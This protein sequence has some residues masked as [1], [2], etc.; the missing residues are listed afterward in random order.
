MKKTPFR[1]AASG[2][3]RRVFPLAL[4]AFVALACGGPAKGPE[5][6][7]TPGEWR[8]FE[9]TL[10]ATGNR[11]ALRLGPDRFATIFSLSG[12]LLLVGERRLGQGFQCKMIGFN[13]NTKGIGGWS[14]W[15][16]T[17]GDQVFSEIKGEPI[18]AGRR[19][20]GT[21]QGGTGRYAGITG[22]YE[23]V[24]KL[25]VGDESTDEATFQGRADG[26]RGRFRLI[27]PASSPPPKSS[28]APEGGRDRS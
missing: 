13:D 17:G 26:L 24:W 4:L 18:G 22:E 5:G 12:S 1:V 11:Q 8:T 21:I 9:G 3:V 16:D 10:N 25:V 23:F 2:H 7:R 14:T 19:I 15:T 20:L 27:P 28:V 6:S